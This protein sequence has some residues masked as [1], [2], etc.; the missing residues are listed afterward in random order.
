MKLHRGKVYPA[1]LCFQLWFQG[2]FYIGW[3]FFAA[4][5]GSW[6]LFSPGSYGYFAG[7]L[8]LAMYAVSSGE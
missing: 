2:W 7:T 8:G 3:S 5:M 1:A 6:T 4:A